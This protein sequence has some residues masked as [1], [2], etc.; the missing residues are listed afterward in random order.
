MIRR[1]ANPP[2]GWNGRW[3]A[4]P[5]GAL[6]VNVVDGK[7]AAYWPVGHAQAMTDAQWQTYVTGA[8]YAPP[9]DEANQATIRQFIIDNMPTLQA[10]IDRPPVTFGNIAGAQTEV[11]KLQV[12]LQN[13][14]RGMR[15]IAREIT[16]DFTGSS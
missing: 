14:A 16:G 1:L 12:D 3:P 2:A 4:P 8:S 6:S 13:V 9:T 11:R 15:R 5:P 10:I 7:L